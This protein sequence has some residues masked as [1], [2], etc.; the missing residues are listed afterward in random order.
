MVDSS[1]NIPHVGKA[2]S[3]PEYKENP[4]DKDR[5]NQKDENHQQKENKAEENLAHHGGDDPD[6]GHIIDIEA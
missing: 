5:R 4:F 2:V 3:V 1:S 6:L